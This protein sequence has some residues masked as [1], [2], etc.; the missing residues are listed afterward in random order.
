MRFL[1]VFSVAVLCLALYPPSTGAVEVKYSQDQYLSLVEKVV[2]QSVRPF[3]SRL[4]I[5]Q[6]QALEDV[7]V[8]VE[9]QFSPNAM[10]LS[11]DETTPKVL[12]SHTFLQGVEAYIEAYLLSEALNNPILI[13]QYFSEYFW[14]H[15]PSSQGIEP[16]L[17]SKRWH[18]SGD[19]QLFLAQKSTLFEAVVLDIL[20]HELGH[21]VKN[22]F[23][24]HRANQYTIEASE[25]L[26]D[27]W[28]DHIKQVFLNRSESIG[29]LIVIGYIFEQDRWATLS[30]D[31]FYPRILPWVSSQLP[32]LC[33]DAE[34]LSDKKFC[35]RLD[36][37]IENYYSSRIETAYLERLQRGDLF[38]NFPLGQ[39]ELA[40]SNFVDACSYFNESFIYGQVARAAIYVGWC[41]QKGYLEPSPPDV[42]VLAM[43]HA[44]GDGSY[45]LPR[46]NKISDR[47]LLSTGP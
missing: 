10:A 6:Q 35:R 47:M 7:V 46:Q 9:R 24:H 42:Q 43:L 3:I 44:R 26:A 32:A 21:H 34:S 30:D 8:S 28:A 16:Y 18:V 25:K 15:H 13:E 41:Y 11:I 23:Y 14:S 39:I 33:E 4:P 29:R 45:G 19:E 20:L 2:D 17:P 5:K 36:Q 37:D 12:I 22:A 27:S 1:L 40:K 31:H 38:A